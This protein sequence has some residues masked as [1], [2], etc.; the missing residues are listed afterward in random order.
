M[1]GLEQLGP[2]KRNLP[3][4][5]Q[6]R[7]GGESRSGRCVQKS[8]HKECNEYMPLVGE[9]TGGRIEQ[10]H[11]RGREPWKADREKWQ[12]DCAPPPTKCTNSRGV[13][14]ASSYSWLILHSM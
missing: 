2:S 10:A 1:R 4:D 3:N 12:P 9:D 5:M 13:P 7:S 14:Q 6:N 8:G 11:A